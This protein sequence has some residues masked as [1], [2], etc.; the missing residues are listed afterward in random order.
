MGN[1]TWEAS[2][3]DKAGLQT[4]P[5]VQDRPGLAVTR[6]QTLPSSSASSQPV[7]GLAPG[8]SASGAPLEHSS[9]FKPPRLW[10]LVKAALRTRI[11]TGCLTHD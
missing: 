9:S 10:S 6:T 2:L 4:C 1:Q 5:Q 7:E 11:H 3:D 8:L